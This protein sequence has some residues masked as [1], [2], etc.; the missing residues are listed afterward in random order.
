MAFDTTRP[1]R[2]TRGKSLYLQDGASTLIVVAAIFII[3][4]GLQM[5]R[6]VVVPILMGSFLAIISYSATYFLRRFLRFPHWLAVTFTVLLDSAVIYGVFL[7]VKYLAADMRATLQGELMAKIAVKYNDLMAFLDKLDLGEQA[8]AVISSPSELFDAKL[9]FSTTQAL[10]GF[11][12]STTLVLILMTFLLA[13]TPL[14]QRNLNRLPT[15]SASKSK[16]VDAILGVQRYLFIKTVASAITGLLAGCL[17]AWMNVPFAFLWGVVA[18]L[19]NYIPTIGSIVAAIP[20]ILLALF[21]G[22]WGEC[23]VVAAG[24][25][26]INCAIGNCIEPI[27]MGKQFGISTSVV[28]LSVLLWG[29]VLGPCGMLLSVPITVLI[30]LAMENSRDLAWVATLIDDTKTEKAILKEQAAQ[31]AAQAQS[32]TPATPATDA[33]PAPAGSP[34]TGSHP[35]PNAT[36]A[37]TEATATWDHT[38]ATP[39]RTTGSTPPSQT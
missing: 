39:S 11:M 13:E 36:P 31:Q 38:T 29:W 19:L 5:A 16:V 22:T 4:L 35:A 14:F 18:Y 8:R 27:F 2:Y 6:T 7:L 21:L 28:L 15:S 26:A 30:K 9:I 20:P 3:L 34:S 37:T 10:T 25:L 23:F 17:C 32:L 24:Y 33:T 1:P 12:A